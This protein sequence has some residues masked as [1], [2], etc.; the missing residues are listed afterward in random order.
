MKYINT[1]TSV[2]IETDSVING[3][4]WR[5]ILPAGQAK[6]KKDVTGNVSKRRTARKPVETDDRGGGNKG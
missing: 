4:D 2:I 1:H 6:E 3:P 5:E